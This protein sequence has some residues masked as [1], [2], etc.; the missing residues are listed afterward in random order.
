[1]RLFRYPLVA[2]F[3]VGIHLHTGSES[4]VY[5]CGRCAGKVFEAERM[6]TSAGS[7]H[8]ACFRCAKCAATLDYSKVFC[9]E[10]DAYCGPCYKEDFGVTSRRARP[11]SR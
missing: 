5:H 11:R 4:V 6:K 10:G 1:M 7:F 3:C 9:S 8:P 2:I